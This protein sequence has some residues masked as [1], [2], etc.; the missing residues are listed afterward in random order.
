[1]N[2]PELTANV[3]HVASQYSQEFGVTYTNDWFLLKL[4]EEFG[5]M[6]RAHLM[7]TNRTRRKAASEL[8]AKKA[9]ADE[10]ADVFAYVLLFAKNMDIDIEAALTKK[11]FAYLPKP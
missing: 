5:E 10:I 7:L 11:W 6:T 1:M 9:L 2:L 4:Q 8:E 3:E